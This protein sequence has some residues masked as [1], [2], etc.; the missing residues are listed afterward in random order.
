MAEASFWDSVATL[1]PG[2]VVT[3]KRLEVRGPHDLAPSSLTAAEDDLDVTIAASTL[4]GDAWFSGVK[5]LDSSF[6]CKFAHASKGKASLV[7]GPVRRCALS[8]TVKGPNP[9]R[10]CT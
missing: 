6:L 3:R 10:R 1:R 4:E 7:P 5:P 2:R 8:A 9:L